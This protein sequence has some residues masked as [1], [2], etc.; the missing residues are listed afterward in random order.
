MS[1]E[2]RVPNLRR[3]SLSGAHTSP[4]EPGSECL[5]V[6]SGEAR[7]EGLDK[8]W[9]LEWVHLQGQAGIQSPVPPPP[10]DMWRCLAKPA[11]PMSKGHRTLCDSRARWHQVSDR[12]PGDGGSRGLGWLMTGTFRR[13]AGGEPSL[14]VFLREQGTSLCTGAWR[15]VTVLRYTVS[16]G[17][18]TSSAP[19]EQ[20]WVSPTGTCGTKITNQNL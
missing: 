17:T 16:K 15:Q 9:D 4:A 13:Q 20:G 1:G 18:W 7:R 12:V 10:P 19:R 3:P 6:H 5:P 14:V 11:Q 8:S 2:L